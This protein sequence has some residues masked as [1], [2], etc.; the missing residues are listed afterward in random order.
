MDRVLV[1]GRV[2]RLVVVEGWLLLFRRREGFCGCEFVFCV[3]H[4]GK[5]GNCLLDCIGDLSIYAQ[6]LRVVPS[7]IG[8][9]P[10][11]KRH[12]RELGSVG[13]LHVAYR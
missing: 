11:Y 6:V 7:E 10:E 13:S 9:V 4:A 12:E 3:G 1:V 5:E 8:S 2:W